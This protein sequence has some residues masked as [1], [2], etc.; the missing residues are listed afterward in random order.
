MTVT[1]YSVLFPRT[2]YINKKIN[3]QTI[4]IL[5]NVKRLSKYFQFMFHRQNTYITVKTKLKKIKRS[6][7]LGVII[8]TKYL[9]FP[10][11]LDFEMVNMT[12]ILLCKQ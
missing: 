11:K 4:N 2:Q 6:F 1:K 8:S 3:E 12:K 7:G 10:V 9:L 5:N